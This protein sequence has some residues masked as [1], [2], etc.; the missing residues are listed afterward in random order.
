[1]LLQKVTYNV[2]LLTAKSSNERYNDQGRIADQEG[3]GVRTPAA[4]WVTFKILTNP[5][6]IF[7]RSEYPL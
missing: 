4:K 1:M 6:G 3:P 5:M 2:L 7:Q